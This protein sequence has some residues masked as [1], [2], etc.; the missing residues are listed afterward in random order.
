MTTYFSKVEDGLVT[1]SI[2]A[3]QDYINALPDAQLWVETFKPDD[4]GVVPYRKNFGNVGSAY[5]ATND[6]FIPKKHFS[7]WTLN[8]TTYQW[9]PPF[10]AP[11]DR[12]YLWDEA[13]LSWK[14]RLTPEEIF[15]IH[16]AQ[17]V[18]KGIL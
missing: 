5:D 12:E 10:P 13:T 3:D 18:A 17:D 9:E 4:S 15:G 16:T 8:T 1:Q 6:V 2:V 14:P 11:T 7:S